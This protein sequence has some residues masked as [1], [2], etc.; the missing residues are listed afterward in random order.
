MTKMK[1]FYLVK[2]TFTFIILASALTAT[3]EQSDVES[4]APSAETLPEQSAKIRF[5]AAPKKLALNIDNKSISWINVLNEQHLVFKRSFKSRIYRGN[6]IL[7]HAPG[8]N[9]L[10]NRLI[11]P[12]SSQMSD[13]GWNTFSSNIGFPD[14]QRKIKIVE[15]IE[16]NQSSQQDSEQQ[17]LSEQKA[18]GNEEPVNPQESDKPEPEPESAINKTEGFFKA[19]SSFQEYFSL[20]CQETLKLVKIT[21]EPTIILA[22]GEAAYWILDCLKQMSPNTP[23]VIIEPSVPFFAYQ[24]LDST[25]E[26]IDNPIFT[27]A[28]EN[29]DDYFVELIKQ[30][31]LRSTKRRFN[32]SALINSKINIENTTIA[33]LITG[34]VKNIN[35]ESQ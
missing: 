11:N 14:F 9:P 33:K 13:L 18:T 27:L 2:Q 32:Q 20:I 7:F 15:T 31:K 19:D 6:V 34:W 1:T 30:Q 5:I 10:H 26:S 8:E 21:E 24:K 23:I 4:V 17:A 35:S 12:L 16:Q 25:L 29:N 28:T 3:A 22:D